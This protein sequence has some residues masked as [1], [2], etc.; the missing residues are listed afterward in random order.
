MFQKVKIERVYY[1]SFTSEMLYKAK[2]LGT[3]PE[4]D[5][6]EQIFAQSQ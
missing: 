1:L 5:L 6:R 2:S 3:P 4:T